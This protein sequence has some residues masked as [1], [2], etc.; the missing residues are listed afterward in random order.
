MFTYKYQILGLVVILHSQLTFG[1][2]ADQTPT[3]RAAIKSEK[4]KFIFGNVA[5][6]LFAEGGD[7]SERYQFQLLFEWEQKETIGG[8]ENRTILCARVLY[9]DSSFGSS[10]SLSDRRGTHYHCIEMAP[11]ARIVL[12][13]QAHRFWFGFLWRQYH[14]MR[15]VLTTLDWGSSGLH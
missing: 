12:Y 7:R 1:V 4:V 2:G 14:A 6:M 10:R 9:L 5:W 15:R 11:P 3:K 13:F 8:G